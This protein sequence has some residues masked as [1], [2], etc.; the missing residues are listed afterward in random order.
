LDNFKHEQ[1]GEDLLV[2]DG[3]EGAL[4]VVFGFSSYTV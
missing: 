4:E 1:G 3:L 2:T